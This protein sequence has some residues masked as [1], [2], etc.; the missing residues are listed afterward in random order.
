MLEVNR[1]TRVCFLVGEFLPFVSCT[2]GVKWRMKTIHQ[3][4]WPITFPDKST[5]C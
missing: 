2:L 3:V 5:V 1:C 4:I